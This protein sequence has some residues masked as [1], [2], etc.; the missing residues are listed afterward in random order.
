MS[1]P[2][3]PPSYPEPV[4]EHLQTNARRVQPFVCADRLWRLVLT[5]ADRERLGDDLMAAYADGGTVGMWVRL[6]GV[7][8]V[9]AVID[10]AKALNLLDEATHRWLLRETGES[11]ED[12]EDV[13]TK[14]APTADLVL[15]ERPRQAFWKG[16]EIPLDWV[17]QDA[18]WKYLWELARA[19]KRDAPLDRFAFS[20]EYATDYLSKQKSKLSQMAEFPANLV[21][22]I[23]P[24][25][26]GTQR[27]DLPQDRIRLFQAD[28]VP[29][30]WEWTGRD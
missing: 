14:V 27:L 17:K 15:V 24:G 11:V 2:S 19:A 8:P 7:S 10:V 30:V 22:R 9:R 18:A 25:G 23:E 12:P 21:D 13:R 3:D 26:A 6:R 1:E 4:L 20:A 29:V 16:E 5:P 28:E